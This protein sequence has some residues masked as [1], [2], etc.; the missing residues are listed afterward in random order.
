MM[1]RGY[2]ALIKVGDRSVYLHRWSE[3][4]GQA[5]A[6]AHRRAAGYGPD[7]KVMWVKPTVEYLRTHYGVEMEEAL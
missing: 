5:I 2:V 4:E 3:N 1:G 6:Y 7:S